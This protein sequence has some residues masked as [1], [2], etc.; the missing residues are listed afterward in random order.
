MIQTLPH[1]PEFARRAA[2]A[3]AVLLFAACA[4]LPEL[5]AAPTLRSA[6]DRA[7]TAQPEGPA[8]DWP[9]DAWWQSYGDAQLARLIDE[10]LRDAPSLRVAEARL[11]RAEA[12]VGI[13]HAASGP[14]VTA[15]VSASETKQSNNYLTPRSMLPQGWNDYGRTT[16]DFSWELDFW[17]KN[18]AAVAAARG[19]R[20]AAAA[21][22][23]QAR[24]LLTSSIAAGYAELARLFAAHDTAAAAVEVRSKTT[25]LFRERQAN[26]L[27]TLGSLRQAESRYA[28]AEGDLLEIDEQIALQR[29]RI[30]ALMGADPERSATIARPAIRLD[31]APGLPSQLALNLLGR[32]PDVVAARL[33]AEAAAKR[34]DAAR[35][36]FYPDV[37]LS[38]F[39][40]VQSLGLDKL[41]KSGSD[42]GSIGP[43]ISLPIFTSGRLQA[44]YT[45][46]RA[47]YDEAVASYDATVTQ[48]LHDVA[49]AVTSQRALA[50]RIERSRA[51]VATAEQAWQIARNRYDGGLSNY[52]DVLTAEDY[53]L[54]T[55]RGL[56]ELQSRAFS[57][58][59]ALVR[60]L[61]GG[62]HAS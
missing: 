10:A 7:A 51:A 5:P 12:N 59:V 34:I 57:L 39:I 21:E 17:G 38:A 29:N 30:A 56:S 19:E 44:Q 2:P 28:T 40:G 54:A 14:Q 25:T 35:A 1:L 24:L 32:R 48:A 61:G 18:R 52:L 16:L 42:M 20:E 13:S 43:A 50:G 26:G 27:E 37:N 8:R 9:V 3:L 33:R 46:R 49:D 36:E 15:N 6:T 22:T 45:G 62:Y 41:F 23:A 55:Q 58:D 4:Q 31:Q 11:L 53:L 47:E 60:A